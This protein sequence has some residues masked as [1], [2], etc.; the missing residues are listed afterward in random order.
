LK[1]LD[2]TKKRFELAKRY[3]Q[4][5]DFKTATQLLDAEHEFQKSRKTPL[6]PQVRGRIEPLVPTVFERSALQEFFAA[7]T[8]ESLPVREVIPPIPAPK[9]KQSQKLLLTNS[10][11]SQPKQQEEDQTS[12]LGMFANSYAAA[13][14]FSKASSFIVEIPDQ[15]CNL[16]IRAWDNLMRE[17][18]KAGELETA[19]DALQKSD[20]L[21]KRANLENPEF[22]RK[23][24]VAIAKLYSQRN[25]PKEAAQLL[26]FALLTLKR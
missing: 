13:R 26:E 11:S 14:S 8:R 19:L 18:I 12:L 1:E 10:V 15:Y 6:L 5:E 7:V 4:I 2:H 3:A 24:L 21:S 9:V 22:V 17:A 25:Q 23:Q 20:R 16:K